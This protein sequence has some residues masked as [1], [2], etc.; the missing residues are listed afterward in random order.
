MMKRGGRLL[1]PFLLAATAACSG[2]SE[3]NEAEA[4]ANA[5][6]IGAESTAEDAALMAQDPELANEAAAD[7]AA[8]TETYGGN[9]AAM[10]T[11]TR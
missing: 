11:N 4:G 10:E 5:A 2:G 3:A 8:D 7:E 9:A 1:T 6:E